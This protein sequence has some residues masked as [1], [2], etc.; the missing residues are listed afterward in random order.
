ML[1]KIALAAMMAAT[2]GGAQAAATIVTPDGV[3][4]FGGFDWASNGSVWISGYDITAGSAADPTKAAGTTDTF[5][6]YYQAV[7]ANIVDPGG[8]NV[9]GLNLRAG[10]GT[11]YEYTINAVL[12]ERVTC[13]TNGCTVVQIDVI[14]GNW[15]I[16]YQ[17][18]GNANPTGIS[19]IID[20]T[21]IVS[22]T[23]DGTSDSVIGPQGASNPGNVTLSGT[24]RGAV[25]YTD[26]S[27]INPTLV[28]S[29]A[30]ST[31]Q[32]G[33]NTT[34]W[35]RPSSFDGLGSTGSNTNSSFVGQADANQAF[36]VAVPEP[37]SLALAGLALCALG[38][39]RRRKSA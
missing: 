8:N 26:L 25:T 5:T 16:Y 17:A 28:S 13:I 39:A 18:V 32:F 29:T 30:V 27:V 15:D 9:P 4:P 20:G 11:G 37:A 19:G 35:T 22:G 1:K 7:A 21:K 10:T 34:S 14:A 23:F 36:A 2:F 31:L 3:K 38:A 6:L 33:S 12:T 24:F